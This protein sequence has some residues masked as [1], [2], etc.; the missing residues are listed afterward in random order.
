MK[1]F[2]ILADTSQDFTFESAKD[3]GVELVSYYLSMGE[4]DYKDQV[5]ID[6]KTFYSVID[7]HDKLSTGVPP[8]QDVIDKIEELKEKGF[9][10]AIVVTSS[11]EITGMNN[12]YESVKNI[13]DDFELFVL[14]SNTVG[15]AAAFLAIEA[16]KMRDK[17]LSPQEIVAKLEL[18]SDQIDIYAIFRSLEYLVKGGRMSPV[19]AAIGGF[20]NIFPILTAKE[21]KVDILEKARGKKKSLERLAQIVKDRIDGAESYYIG[22]FQGDNQEEVDQLKDMLKEQIDKADLFLETVLTP[23]LGVHAGPEALGVSVLTF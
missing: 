12:L 19:K 4:K 15:S 8:I 1:K 23:V 14:D 7:Q 5:D 11:S 10:G 17:G 6:K 3:F 2:A 21:K 16:A 22:I 13:I 9:E 20:L 18:L